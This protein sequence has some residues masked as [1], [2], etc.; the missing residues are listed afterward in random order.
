[1]EDL[2][3]LFPDSALAL[4]ILL[5]AR[6]LLFVLDAADETFPKVKPFTAVLGRLL[7]GGKAR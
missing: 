4:K 2:L 6:V 5:A 7:G 1:M 3:A